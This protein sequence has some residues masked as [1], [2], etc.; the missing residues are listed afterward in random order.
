MAA[1]KATDEKLTDLRLKLPEDLK[2]RIRKFRARKELKDQPI[3]S[4][5]K[6]ILHLVGRGLE[7]E[8]A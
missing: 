3:T 2:G 8:K 6:A 4:D 5:A 1:K 7:V